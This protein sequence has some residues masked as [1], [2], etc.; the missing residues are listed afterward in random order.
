MRNLYQVIT[1]NLSS[2]NSLLYRATTL[3]EVS[4]EMGS[5]RPYICPFIR[6]KDKSQEWLISCF[7]IFLLKLESDKVR[8][9]RFSRKK[10]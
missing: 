3:T 6:T 1:V 5:V 10:S 4:Y 2:L 7:L 8:K 9:K